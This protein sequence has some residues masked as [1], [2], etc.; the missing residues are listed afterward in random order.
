MKIRLYPT[1][2]QKAL[3]RTYAAAAR[4]PCNLCVE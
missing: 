1:P 4:T 2:E 3:F